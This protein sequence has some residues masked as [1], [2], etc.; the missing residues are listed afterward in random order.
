MAKNKKKTTKAKIRV[1]K[2][3]CDPEPPKRPPFPTPSKPWD[4]RGGPDPLE[5]LKLGKKS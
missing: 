5:W 4:E 1:P 3:P 2:G